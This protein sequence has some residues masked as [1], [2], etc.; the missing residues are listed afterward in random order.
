MNFDENQISQLIN[1]NLDNAEK[2]WA[3]VGEELLAKD[4]MLKAAFESVSNVVQSKIPGYPLVYDN[5]S[6]VDEFIALVADMRKSSEHLMCAISPKTADVSGMQ[7]IYY[8][9]TAL[10]PAL[11]KIIQNQGGN[12][13][14]YLGDGVLA[15]FK[16]DKENKYDAIYA[17]NRAATQSV[18]NLREV[19]NNILK[20]RY[21]L[22]PV[23]IGVGLAYSRALVTLV[24]LENE[25]QAKV[26]G[27]C[28]FRA[29]KLS[30]GTNQVIVD[31]ALNSL[32]PTGKA[33]TI[34]F[35]PKT[36]NGVSGFILSR[37]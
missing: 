12:V 30:S 23:D 36:M 11:A 7:R 20:E 25:K 17:A 5:N 27:E 34:K 13:T 10:L 32:W 1:K 35:H 3:K 26:F 19:L 22:P 6:V 21:R 16:V 33:G 31:S 4:T 24:G 37:N 14:E 15:L 28:V 2:T 8:E 29:T 18:A 9:T